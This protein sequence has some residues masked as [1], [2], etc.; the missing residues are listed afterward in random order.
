MKKSSFTFILIL[1]HF[2]CANSIEAKQNNFSDK[3]AKSFQTIDRC[4]N[5]R[6]W[7]ELYR[8]SCSLTQLDGS[9]NEA[10]FFKGVGAFHLGEYEIANESF[11]NYL[12]LTKDSS[13]H[14]EVIAYKLKIADYFKKGGKKH[15]MGVQKLPRLFSSKEEALQIYEEVLQALP[16]DH[17]GGVAL[18]HKGEMAFEAKEYKEAI[19]IFESVIQRFPQAPLSAD[20][21]IKIGLSY[22]RE[23]LDSFP[24]PHN[25]ELAVL[26]KNNFERSFPDHKKISVLENYLDEMQ[27]F[28]AKSLFETAQFY[29][30]RGKREASSVYYNQILKKYEK[31]VTAQKVR[32]ILGKK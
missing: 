13:K 9:I 1:C 14:K 20:S 25:M 11:S 12:S 4:V 28:F 26:N 8:T 17:L 22:L 24:D 5:E 21:F 32:N 10:W 19:E 3:I 2:L 16:Y 15:L 7:K 30:K 23:S 29:Q 18:F 27:E 31:T 6:N